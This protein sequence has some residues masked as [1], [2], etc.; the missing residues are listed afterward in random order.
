VLIELTFWLLAACD[1]SAG[2]DAMTPEHEVGDAS[3][4]G[5]QLP[6]KLALDP[7]VLPDARVGQL[8]EQPISASGGDGPYT[9]TLGVDSP[10][11]L[12]LRAEQDESATLMGMPEHSGSYL[13]TVQ[14]EDASSKVLAAEWSLTVK[15][16]HWVAFRGTGIDGDDVTSGMIVQELA[17]EEHAAAK[18]QLLPYGMGT[19]WSGDGSWL[20]I[21][22]PRSPRLVDLGGREPAPALTLP[23][24]GEYVSK[25]VAAPKGP[26]FV[27][28]TSP[29]A[30]CTGG[31]AEC[32][33][34]R[35]PRFHVLDLSQPEPVL[36]AI[37]TESTELYDFFWAP[38]GLSL[39]LESGGEGSPRYELIDFTADSLAPRPL[40]G[41]V[42]DDRTGLPT[43][44]GLRW[45]SPTHPATAPSSCAETQGT[46]RLWPVI[47]QARSTRGLRTETGW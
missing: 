25:I 6:V 38:D 16:K 33:A 46:L 44:D 43:A 4:D 31:E 5:G 19:Q 28:E 27:V 9:W 21:G 10:P 29:N 7:R 24:A 8:F 26:R 22:D 41:S 13:A 3:Q 42:V 1:G 14:V 30:S 15:P 45:R 37:P 47:S 2:S 34:H 32:E 12:Q 23:L 35:G 17:A 18:P 36:E 40:P 11:W 39:V 20:V